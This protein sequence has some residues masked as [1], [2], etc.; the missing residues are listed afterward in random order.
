MKVLLVCNNAFIQG[1]GICT[2]VQSLLANLR[3][4]GIDTRLM[5]SANPDPEGKQPDYKLAHFKIPLF[6]PLIYKNGFRFAA[7]D[8]QIMREAVE[9]ADIIHLHEAF[10]LQ[11]RTARIARELGKPCVATFHLFPQN[12]IANAIHASGENLLSKGLM[13]W[14]KTAVFNKCTYI[15]C[16]SEAARSY[17]EENGVTPP[18]MV[19]SN[20]IKSSHPPISKNNPP[21]DPINIICIGRYAWEK[22]QLTLLDAMKAS[23]HAGRIQLWFAGKGPMEKR[24][25]KRAQSLVNKGILKHGPIFGYY[26][27]AGLEDLRSRAWLLV[28]CATVEMEGLS[29]LESI[30]EGVVPIIAEGKLTATSQFA[31]DHRSTFPVNNPAALAEKID[32]W[33]EHPQERS[34]MSI[35]YA[36]SASDYSA[37]N[38]TASMIGMYEKALSK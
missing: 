35:R 30:A 27:K 31:L 9:W 21:S 25:K 26:D 11:I 19:C 34:K 29:C 36:E 14:W 3:I 15:H 33:I 32:W 2:A 38:S 5:A 13:Y 8:P 12:V 23:K 22:S 18:K 4:A 16:P 20:G 7:A 37:D 1:N 24:L 28:H 17:L 10:P 6:E